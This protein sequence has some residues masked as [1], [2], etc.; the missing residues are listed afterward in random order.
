MRTL[1]QP[2]QGRT[3]IV[4]S[5]FRP[6][7]STT[8]SPTFPW[9]RFCIAAILHLHCNQGGK[10]VWEM[11]AG[12]PRNYGHFWKLEQD[13]FHLPETYSAPSRSSSRV[14]FSASSSP[15]SDKK[16]FRTIVQAIQVG[17]WVIFVKSSFF[18]KTIF[19]FFLGI[20]KQ[21]SKQT[22]W[23]NLWQMVILALGE[24]LSLYFGT[25]NSCFV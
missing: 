10:Q 20:K 8:L 19:E 24:F 9:V 13:F 23:N 3:I 25:E 22:M 12:V 14:L 15:K 18:A 6:L 11:Q 21:T 1:R 4:C 16:K 17:N 2:S 7:L 5:S